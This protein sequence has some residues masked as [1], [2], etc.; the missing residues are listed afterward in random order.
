M[1]ECV[2]ECDEP[3]QTEWEP[4]AEEKAMLR[5]EFLSPMH[6]RFLDGK[7]DF[8][9]SEVDE[10][11]DYDNLNILSCDAEERYFDEEVEKEE[12]IMQ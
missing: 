1:D 5:E 4:N 9:Y 10:N 12:D 7:D 6:Q 8:N 3:R 11:P 2:L